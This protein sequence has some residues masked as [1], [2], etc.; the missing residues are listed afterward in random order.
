MIL[1]SA[2]AYEDLLEKVMKKFM[3]FLT[4]TAFFF[5]FNDDP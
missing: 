5:F 2:K 3:K 4:L 1:L